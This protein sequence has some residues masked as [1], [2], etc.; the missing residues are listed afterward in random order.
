LIYQDESRGV[1]V[2]K[3]DGGVQ[4]CLAVGLDHSSLLARYL[5]S[6]ELIVSVPEVFDDV[7]DNEGRE[8]VCLLSTLNLE[9][10][11]L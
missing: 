8:L 4:Y 9:Y 11:K 7:V 5:Q 6:N 10:S 1:H 2:L 3:L